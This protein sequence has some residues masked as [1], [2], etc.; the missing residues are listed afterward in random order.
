MLYPLAISYIAEKN[1]NIYKEFID[2]KQTQNKLQICTRAYN[3]IF[4]VYLPI[5]TCIYAINM[6][7]SLFIH[8]MPY[9]M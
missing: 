3:I 9:F 7:M 6:L 8:R 1:F 2:I 5:S 4:S